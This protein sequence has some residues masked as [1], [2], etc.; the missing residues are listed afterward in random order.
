MGLIVSIP[1]F[2]N[3]GFDIKLNM[4]VDMTLKQRKE[5]KPNLTHPDFNESIIY[6]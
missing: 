3:D 1:V 6:K 5:T 4:K 2:N